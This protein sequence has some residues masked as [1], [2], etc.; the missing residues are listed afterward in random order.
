MS[1][2]DGNNVTYRNIDTLMDEPSK[3]A[4]ILQPI[5]Q[6]DHARASLLVGLLE[7]VAN[8]PLVGRFYSLVGHFLVLISASGV[9]PIPVFSTFAA[10]SLPLG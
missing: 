6:L 1:T 5:G 7:V 8:Q 3:R 2:E 9:V 4:A 10:T